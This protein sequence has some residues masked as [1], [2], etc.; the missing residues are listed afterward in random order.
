VPNL[1]ED[2]L[3]VKQHDSAEVRQQDSL[4]IQYH[5]ET[6]RNARIKVIGVGGGGNNAINRMIAANVEG[7]EF[8][9]ANTDVQ[10]LEGSN[11]PVKL[12]LGVKLTSGLGAGANPDVGRR[13]ALEDSDKIIEALEG[14]DMV[15]VTAGLGGGTGTGAAP[16]IASLASEMGAL[17]IAVVTRPFAFEGK[18]RAMQAERGLQELLESVDT[19]IVIP[20]DKLLT[21]AKDAGFFESFRIADDILRQ[22]VQGISDIIT[23]PGVINRD[24]ADV[25]TTMA[26]MG[27]S[28][29]GTAVRSGEN[30]AR[31]AAM[32]AIASPLLEAGAI[33]GAR[34]ILINITGSSGLKLSEVIEASS[35]IQEA[36][37]EDANIIFGAVLDESLGDEVKFTVIAT[38]FREAMPARRERMMAASALPTAHHE[39]APPRIVSRPLVPRF[40]REP[41]AA[42]VAQPVIFASQAAQPSIRFASETEVEEALGAVPV[43]EPKIVAA[44]PVV[45]PVAPARAA[46]PVSSYYETARQQ[47]WQE[48]TPRVEFAPH[49]DEHFDEPMPQ[50]EEVVEHR[51]AG[52][53]EV[54]S[55]PV[56]VVVEHIPEVA[57]GRTIEVATEG[58]AAVEMQGAG[59]ETGHDAPVAKETSPELIP[60]RASVFDDD[61]FRR[62]KDDLA[63][64][65]AE[66]AAS[67]QWPDARVPSFAGYAGESSAENDEL[68]IPAFL[69]RKQ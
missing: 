37:H 2:P 54:V 9:S 67:K 27:Y 36:A 48:P 45:A 55:A 1:P 52:L 13:A 43:A 35:I 46:Y 29:M 33:D 63:A 15:F 17:T 32:A 10:A 18:R 39:V 28:V 65:G 41:E 20:N 12:Q 8:I 57:Q 50:V 4:R 19:L 22:G 26:G 56:P 64:K 61:F 21:T 40:S 6:R 47:A 16:V 31:E 62:P 49:V 14:A 7:V 34:G 60:V 3:G 69:R 44:E 23:I 38:G 24:F 58:Y 51:A 25:K 68:D 11:A 66:D 59:H 5:E 30:R 53:A 42:E